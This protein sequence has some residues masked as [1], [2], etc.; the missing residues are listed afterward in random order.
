MANDHLYKILV[1]NYPN[2]KN[3]LTFDLLQPVPS[4][5][6]NLDFI[7]EIFANSNPYLQTYAQEIIELAE[8]KLPIHTRHKLINLVNIMICNNNQDFSHGQ[9]Y[10]VDDI[11]NTTEPNINRNSTE[12]NDVTMEESQAPQS[13]WQKSSAKYNWS[14]CPI[15]LLPWQ[16]PIA[17]NLF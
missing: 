14:S 2:H 11:K 15:G 16:D 1:Q 6:T 3:G 12:C 7:Q 13:V 9:I 10:T 5:L 17:I 4:E 8:P